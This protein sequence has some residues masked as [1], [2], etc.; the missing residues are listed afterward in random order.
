MAYVP[1][2]EP[3]RLRITHLLAWTAA[4]AVWLTVLQLMFAM[5]HRPRDIVLASVV[6]V[7][8]IQGAWLT[9]LLLFLYRWQRGRGFA[10]QP[11]DWLLVAN[12]AAVAATLMNYLHSLAILAG[13]SRPH[14]TVLAG[15][16]PMALQI[17]FYAAAAFRLDEPRLWRRVFW[18]LAAL[19]AF[20]LTCD[21]VGKVGLSFFRYSIALH[22]WLASLNH[23]L[24]WY[25]PAITA[26]GIVGSAAFVDW[27]TGLSRPWTHWAGVA[28]VVAWGAVSTVGLVAWIQGY[29]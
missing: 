16:A 1:D 2:E 11:G 24:V 27:K 19:A 9:G 23:P 21:L 8:P 12:G 17:V 26:G 13:W 6:I 20:R 28:A 7:A 18:L 14:L 29:G 15:V 5:T 22:N 4:T 3:S 10:R 25:L